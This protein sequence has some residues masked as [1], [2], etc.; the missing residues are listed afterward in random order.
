M[1]F[2]SRLRMAA[3]PSRMGAAT[4]LSMA[5]GLLFF[6]V[7]A[8]FSVPSANT[9][10]SAAVAA[11]GFWGAPSAVRQFC[12]PKYATSHYVAEFYNSLSSF[13][14]VGGAAYI[15]S[16]PEIRRDPMMVL[17]AAAVAVIGLGSVA[18][19]DDAPTPHGGPG[20]VDSGAIGAG[21]AA[22]AAGGPGPMELSALEALE[23]G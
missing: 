16:K 22:E 1:S 19:L 2:F 13:V 5:V 23:A 18:D 3:R 4:A 10:G 21:E 7:A 12:E 15:L 9:P 11:S 17:A 20:D 8:F 6:L 14:Y